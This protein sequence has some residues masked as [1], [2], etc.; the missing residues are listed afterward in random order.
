M[1]FI[2]RHVNIEALLVLLVFCLCLTGALLLP[3]D[4]CPDEAGRHFLSNWIVRTG[5]LPTGN[6]PETMLMSWEDVNAPVLSIRAGSEYDGWGFS[7]ALRPYLSSIVGAAFERIASCFTDSPRVLLAASRMCSVLSVTLC[8]FFC[9]RLGRRLFARRS[10]ALLFAAIVCFLPQGMFLG[11][12]QNNDSLAL[13]AVS[14]MLY[15]LIE[16]FDRK[17]PVTSCIGLAAAF[18]LGLLS[19]YSVYGWLL[20]G[21]LFC[22]A[23]A[24]TDRDI[25]DKG[26]LIYKRTGL[27]LGVC[28]LLAGWFFIRN[29]YYHNGDF[30]GI[31]SEEISRAEMRSRGY[32]LHEYVN[33]RN[34]GMTIP[35]FLRMGDH[36]WL[37]L[38]AWSFVGVFGYMDILLP[39]T[40]Y[41]LYG[42]VIAGG[43]LLYVASLLRQKPSRR[44]GLLALMMLLASLLTVLMHFW[45]SY[46]R[47]YQ[48][49]G[50]YIITLAI[51]FAYMLTYGLDGLAAGGGPPEKAARSRTVPAV[52]LTVLWLALFAWAALGTMTKMLP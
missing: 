29:A 42:A 46:A 6:E 11:M 28:V 10:T 41:R 43:A 49:Q 50:R 22:V 5:T 25:P 52:A 19:Y 27:I 15:Y 31:A 45:Q 30:F 47:D 32:R 20:S 9:L 37:R 44:D 21:A 17:W 3:L 8:C 12:Y 1:T 35:D 36:W 38:S 23:A 2:K 18:S 48:P 16:G 26:R 40:Q 4:E 34:E 13:C 7:Y 33:Y 24:L 14:M 39:R 51:P